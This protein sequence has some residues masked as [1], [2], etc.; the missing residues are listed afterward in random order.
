MALV[1]RQTGVQTR[2]AARPY[3]NTKGFPMID[4]HATGSTVVEIGS[5]KAW[6]TGGLG[7]GPEPAEFPYQRFDS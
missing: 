6:T 7:A 4:D 1:I 3:R 5:A 2:T